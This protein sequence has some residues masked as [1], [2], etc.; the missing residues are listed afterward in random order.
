[1]R[2]I[3]GGGVE[4]VVVVQKGSQGTG[5]PVALGQDGQLRAVVQ[6]WLQLREPRQ[7]IRHEME[8]VVAVWEH[9]AEVKGG[10]GRLEP[11]AWRETKK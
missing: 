5:C 3:R 11:V 4:A 8:E 2:P 7:H 1:M 6:Q 9:H 10:S